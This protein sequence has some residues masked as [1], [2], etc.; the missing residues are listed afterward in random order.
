M[1]SVLKT[2][3]L[4]VLVSKSNY[5]FSIGEN[6]VRT[7]SYFNLSDQSYLRYNFQR[8]NLRFNHGYYLVFV[9]LVSL[10]KLDVTF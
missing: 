10:K 6:K 7:F 8:T 2:T 1:T 9:S 5:Y 4:N 3:L